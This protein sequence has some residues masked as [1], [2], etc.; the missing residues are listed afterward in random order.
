VHGGPR[1]PHGK[2]VLSLNLSLYEKDPMV[3][4]R[5]ACR[6][7]SIARIRNASTLSDPF[8][9]HIPANRGHPIIHLCGHRRISKQ[10]SDA[11]NAAWCPRTENTMSIGFQVSKQAKVRFRRADS[12]TLCGGQSNSGA[13]G[14]IVEVVSNFNH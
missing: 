6:R 12:V 14:K 10:S 3:F 1:A 4:S 8:R 9:F 5:L 13:A 2:E 7:I 11:L